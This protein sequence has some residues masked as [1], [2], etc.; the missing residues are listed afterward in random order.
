MTTPVIEL[1][2]VSRRYDDGPPALHEAS[3]TVRPGEA[4]AILGPSGSGKSTLLNLIAGLDRPDTGTV[5]VDGVRVDRLGEAGSA[6]F[7]RSKIGMVFQFFNLLDDLTVIDNVVLPARLSGVARGEAGRRAAELLETLGID[8]HARAYPGRLSGG[9]RQRVAV[10]R[11][12]MNRPALL[13][14]DEPT[15]ALDTAAGQDVSTLLN[16]LNAEGQTI[17]VVTHDLALARSCTNRT[18]RIADGRITEDIRSQAAPQT[19]D[20]QTADP[21]TADP[22]TADP[23]T[24]A[25][26][27][28]R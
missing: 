10:A 9:E 21:Q 19:A 17:V 2:G 24:A 27:A 8:R 18:V 26:Q 25:P 23:Q 12:L 1:R 11:A 15:G 13:L 6:L 3:L 20:P 4:V 7:R 28:V 22:Q 16:T 5:T 14:A